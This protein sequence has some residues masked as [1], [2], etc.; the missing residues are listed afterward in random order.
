MADTVTWFFVSTYSGKIDT[1]DQG[2]PLHYQTRA[3]AEDAIKTGEHGDYGTRYVI[4]A[5]LETVSTAHRAWEL[6]AV[7]VPPADPFTG[8][9]ATVPGDMQTD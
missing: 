3:D 5:E 4:K 8:G 9:R 6:R 1:D 2:S 7:G